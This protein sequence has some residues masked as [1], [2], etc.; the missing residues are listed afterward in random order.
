MMEI[1]RKKI[2]RPCKTINYADKSISL[3]TNTDRYGTHA[4]ICI[5]PLIQKDNIITFGYEIRVV[6]F[7]YNHNRIFSRLFKDCYK[8][9][10]FKTKKFKD[11][12]KIDFA[13]DL[14]KCEEEFK[15]EYVYFMK[16]IINSNIMNTI[17]NV[18]FMEEGL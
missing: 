7:N 13:N 18:V 16:N 6:V 9:N 14:Q 8:A 12:L 5:I 11:S 4:E 1:I 15:E 2:K 10:D 17:V 3:Y